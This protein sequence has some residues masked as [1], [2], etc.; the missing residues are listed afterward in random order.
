MP[1]K[2]QKGTNPVFILN[3]SV[4]LHAIMAF[5]E[6]CHELHRPMLPTPSSAEK[7]NCSPRLMDPGCTLS[8]ELGESDQ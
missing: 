7:E 1:K 3:S 6:A 4:R 2:K 8:R 5:W